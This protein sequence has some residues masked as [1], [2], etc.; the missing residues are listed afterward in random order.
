MKKRQQK[1]AHTYYK[2]NE[3]EIRVHELRARNEMTFFFSS[4]FS[5]IPF[6]VLD[7]GIA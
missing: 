3:N 7:K 6:S 2:T 5:C 1:K 4:L